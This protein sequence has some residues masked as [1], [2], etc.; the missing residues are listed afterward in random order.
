MDVLG[1]VHD[2]ECLGGAGDEAKE[3]LDAARRDD[4]GRDEQSADPRGRHHFRLT[5]LRAGHSVGASL[6]LA[7]RDLGTAVRLR[8]GA[9]PLAMRACVG[10]H[11]GHVSL[12]P[13]EVEEESRRRDLVAC[14]EFGEAHFTTA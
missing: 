14:H 10:R 3:A 13:V 6:D 1:V 5:E 12:E 2:D 11:T 7:P 8:V 4:F 9:Q